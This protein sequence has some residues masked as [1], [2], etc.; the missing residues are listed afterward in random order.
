VAAFAGTAFVGTAFAGAAVAGAAVDVGAFIGAA[1]A[2]GRAGWTGSVAGIVS[3]VST[4]AASTTGR[5]VLVAR[6][7]VLR[8]LRVVEARVA[9]PAAAVLAPGSPGTTGF[10]AAFLGALAGRGASPLW[11]PSAVVRGATADASAA[12]TGSVLSGRARS[13]LTPLTYQATRPPVTPCDEPGDSGWLGKSCEEH[14]DPATTA[15]NP[16]PSD[17]CPSSLVAA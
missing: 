16:C 10:A 6:G 14:N 15:V 11:A 8:G 2:D 17:G 9:A 3:V 5:L 13:K 1:F 12:V 7:V 4:I